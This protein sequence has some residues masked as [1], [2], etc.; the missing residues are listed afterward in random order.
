MTHTATAVAATSTELPH[1]ARGWP[2]LSQ[3]TRYS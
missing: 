3:P 2:E 1:A